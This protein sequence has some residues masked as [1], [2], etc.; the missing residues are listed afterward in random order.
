MNSHIPPP[1]D[2]DSYDYD[3]PEEMIAQSPVDKRDR[4]RLLVMDCHA[5]QM[6]D[7]RFCDLVD[8][9]R[10]GDLLVANNTK[11]FPARLLGKKETGGKMELLILEY[12]ETIIETGI[13]SGN[14][15]CR[16]ALV[17]GLV[18]SSKRP[19]L[20]SRLIFSPELE[21]IVEKIFPDGKV[22]VRLLFQGNLEDVL[23]KF[24]Q[25]PLP[26]YIRR[27]SGDQPADRSRY[28]TVFAKETG[29]V[30]APTAGLHLTE[31]LLDTLR[32]KQVG[33]CTVT[34]HVG[35]GTFAPVRVQDIR[36]HRIHSEFL[37]VTED[38]AR[39]INETRKAGHR[40]FAV[41][42]TTVR[43]LEFAADD[44]GRVNQRQGWCDLYIYPGYRFKV[45]RNLITNF[46]LPRSSL[47]FMVSGLA[48]REWILDGYRH[49][50]ESGYRFFSYG[51]AMLI[52]TQEGER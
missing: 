29:A 17:I 25:T 32:E 48:G 34:L 33:F 12:P 39:L 11:V 20:K 30:A 47:L 21:G 26:P 3:L 41:G 52:M 35:Y 7:H 49:A 37:S 44:S 10:P 19:G 27:K 1:Y 51:D 5:K 42:T 23:E 6:S 36:E 9:L 2:I 18:K 24:G 15:L 43:A 13:Q 50:V 40:V 16:E 14:H 31:E 28:Q 8:F 45:V 46:H 4:S 22:S 38:T